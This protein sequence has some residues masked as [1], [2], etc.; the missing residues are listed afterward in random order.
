MVVDATDGAPGSFKDRILLERDPHLV[1]AGTILASHA[2]GAVEAYLLI[3]AEYE[4]AGERCRA[5]VDEAQ[6]AGLLGRGLGD[7]PVVI[8]IR[9]RTGAS[10]TGDA[11]ALVAALEGRPPSRDPRRAVPE[12]SGLFDRPTLIETADTLAQVPA[13]CERGPAWFKGLGCQGAVGLKI[14]SLSGDVRR[15]GNYE[16]PRG[17]PLR[18]LVE[19]LGGGP[20]SG[21]EVAAVMIGGRGGGLLPPSAL[22]LPL[23]EGVLQAHGVG[24]GSGAIVV[25]SDKTCLLDLARREVAFV[26][27]ETSGAC[28]LCRKGAFELVSAMQTLSSDRAASGARSSELDRELP[29]AP[30]CSQGLFALSVAKGLV[31]RFPEAVTSHR[32]G[33]CAC[34]PRRSGRT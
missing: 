17:T 8:R 18:H 9:V 19:E 16:L 1:I 4:L 26:A 22:A 5:A 28:E 23:I 32:D 7:S 11:A 25:A 3:R 31:G 2:V 13:L 20:L 29:C 15:P 14:F 33:S 24:L 30:C 21:K 10:S 34:H 6:R 12:E 27:R